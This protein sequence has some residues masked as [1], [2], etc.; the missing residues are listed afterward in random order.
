MIPFNFT[1]LNF[2]NFVNTLDDDIKFTYEKQS[3]SSLDFLDTS[4]KN[5]DNVLEI[6]WKLKETNTGLYI[7]D[8]AHAPKSYKLAAM[9]SLFNRAKRISSNDLLYEEAASKLTTLFEQN[10]YNKNLINT[11]RNEVEKKLTEDC[12]KTETES[13]GA[14]IIYWKLPYFEERHT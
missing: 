4:I 12:M 13:K 7:P 5:N 9:K 2:F 1:K 14:K 10:G 11:V 6:S 8:K 3:E